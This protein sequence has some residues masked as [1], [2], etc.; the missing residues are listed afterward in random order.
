MMRLLWA[1]LVWLGLAASA[2]AAGHAWYG[3]IWNRRAR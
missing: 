1:V 2:G 3:R